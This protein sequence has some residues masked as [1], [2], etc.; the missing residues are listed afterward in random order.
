MN[1]DHLRGSITHGQADDNAPPPVDLGKVLVACDWP[2]PCMVDGEIVRASFNSGIGGLVQKDSLEI[3][4]MHDER[5]E[6]FG[7]R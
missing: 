2:M 1:V 3:G 7:S 5:I 6:L 4:F